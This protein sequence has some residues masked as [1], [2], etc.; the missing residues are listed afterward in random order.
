MANGMDG[1]RA[2]ARRVASAAG[3]VADALR[4]RGQGYFTLG[5]GC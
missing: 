2:L 3:G 5:A 1:V 4:L